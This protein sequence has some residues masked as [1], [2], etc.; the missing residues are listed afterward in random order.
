MLKS[1]IKSAARNIFKYKFY[2]S[3][4][5]LGLAIGII[6]AILIMMYIN[7]DLSYDKH[8]DKHERIYRLESDFTISGKND[9]FAI[10]QIPLSPTLMDEYPEI[11]NY[12][13]F[14]VL[15]GRLFKYKEMEFFEDSVGICDSTI[16]DV[17]T[18]EFVHGSEENALNSPNTMV[19]SESFSQKY[20]GEINPIGEVI[21]TGGLGDITVTGVIKNSPGNQHLKFNCLISV[22]TF[23]ELLGVERFNDRSASAFWNIAVFSYVLLQENASIETVLE[24]F[25]EFYEKYMKSIGDQINGDFNL[26]A[27][28]LAD[29][30]F[31]SRLVGDR[32]VGDKSNIIIFGFV[33]LFIVLIACINYMNMATARSSNRAREVGVRKVIGA[34]KS[35]LVRQFI[36]ES[37]IMAFIAL[38]I[39]ILTIYVILPSFNN[40]ADKSL[41]FSDIGQIK[42][43]IGII[44]VTLFVGIISGSYPAFY[45]SSFRPVKVLKGK[46]SPSSSRGILRKILVIFQFAISITMIAGTLIVSQQQKFIKNMDLGFKRE[47]IVFMANRDTTFTKNISAFRE[48]LLSYSNITKVATGSSTMGNDQQIIVFRVQLDD[49]MVEKGL[50]LMFVD[51]DFIEMLELELLEG[52]IYDRDHG[53][54]VTNSFIINEA[55]AA[56]LGWEG[57]AIGKKMQFGINLDGTAARDGEVIGLLKDFQYGSVKNPIAPFV[58]LLQE[59]PSPIIYI[60]TTGNDPAGTLDFIRETYKSFDPVWPFD[61]EYLEDHINEQY[62]SEQKLGVLFTIFSIMTIFICCLGLLGLSSYVIDQRTKEIGIRKVMG[63]SNSNIILVLSKGFLFLVLVSNIVAIPVALLFMDKWLQ[64]FHYKIKLGPL[65]FILAALCGLIISILTIA[66]HSVKAARTNPAEALKHE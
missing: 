56:I 54:D 11:E 38:I 35:S 50:N 29:I 16:F 24:K 42:Y 23:V 19:I 4:N 2:S 41:S 18:H 62:V 51:Y 52:R 3:I 46:E 30:H 31:T 47:N 9:Q 27:T 55:A 36:G 15:E 13:R 44:V 21:Q 14:Q 57:E 48:E 61:Y 25:P 63:S 53:A 7:D 43:I 65:P 28:P 40:L 66:Y 49:G 45:L 1:F 64:A 6:S 34:N 26:M 39:A 22:A 33:A 60:N 5:I 59:Q 17:F 10:T 8:H 32:P 20:F 58:L 12:V 37:I